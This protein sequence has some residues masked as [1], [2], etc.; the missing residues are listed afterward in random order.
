MALTNHRKLLITPLTEALS[1]ISVM[2]NPSSYSIS[3]S[4]TWSTPGSAFGKGSDTDRSVNAPTLVFG[5]GGSRQLSLELFFDVT[6]PVDGRTIRDVREKTDA[7]VALTRIDPKQG[8]PPVCQVTWGDAPGRYDLPVTGV[9]TSLSQSFTLF[10]PTGEPVRATL[11]VTFLEFL[12]PGVDQ[13]LTD[14]E[15]TTRVVRGGDSLPNIAAEF[16]GD[17]RMWRVIAEA[18][19]LVD[20][21]RLGIGQTLTIPKVS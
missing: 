15:L 13:R 2:F 19:D 12:D 1:A 16:Y 4:V 21:Q 11:S 8:R 10:R 9:V 20:P 18:N 6:E 5:G 3:K 17:P 7:I 14:P